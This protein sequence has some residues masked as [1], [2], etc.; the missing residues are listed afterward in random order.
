[1]ADETNEVVAWATPA[2]DWQNP[3]AATSPLRPS[4]LISSPGAHR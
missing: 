1:M 4:Q 3:L 2:E